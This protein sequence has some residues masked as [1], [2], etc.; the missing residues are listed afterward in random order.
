MTSKKVYRSF[1]DG[2]PREATLYEV[3]AEMG[4]SHE[5]ARQL[6]VRAIRKLKKTL[7]DR[8]G[9]SIS[10]YDILPTLSG[11]GDYDEQMQSL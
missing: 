9:D 11:R 10:L 2:I 4:I 6:E 8:Y 1:K 3:A 7:L 5:R